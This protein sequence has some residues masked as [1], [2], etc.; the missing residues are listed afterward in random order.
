[1][2]AQ[3]K[4][5]KLGDK[6]G[7]KWYKKARRARDGLAPTIEPVLRTCPNCFENR[8]MCTRY[9]HKTSIH[10][11]NLLSWTGTLYHNSCFRVCQ[12]IKVV[13][14]S[15]LTG[16]MITANRISWTED[17]A[18][19]I[20]RKRRNRCNNEKRSN[21]DQIHRNIGIWVHKARI[22]IRKAIWPTTIRKSCL[23]P[24]LAE[25]FCLLGFPISWGRFY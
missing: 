8:Q 11:G 21:A 4:A 23:S 17:C 1:M 5:W 10:S 25:K 12:L 24:K 3:T 20:M 16:S 9:V 19:Q 15:W 6:K 13:D 18:P 2:Q 14:I 7:L 22:S